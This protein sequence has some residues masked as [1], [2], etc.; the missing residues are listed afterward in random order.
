MTDR[1]FVRLSMALLAAALL[2]IFASA[3]DKLRKPNVLLI[4]VDD[5]N[6]DLCCYGPSSRQVPRY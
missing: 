3:A 2:P 5:L 1:F 4:V 6:I